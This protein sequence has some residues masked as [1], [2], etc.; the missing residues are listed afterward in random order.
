MSQYVKFS[1]GSNIRYIFLE[2]VL[3]SKRLQ[4]V[5]KRCS[6]L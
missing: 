6:T 4:S 2:A 1:L 5:K 3:R